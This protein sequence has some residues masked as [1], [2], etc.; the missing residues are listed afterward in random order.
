MNDLI[1]FV[2]AIVSLFLLHYLPDKKVEDEQ[3]AL[4]AVIIRIGR[5]WASLLLHSL[6]AIDI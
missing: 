5:F 4:A 6:L 3:K 1:L 2:V